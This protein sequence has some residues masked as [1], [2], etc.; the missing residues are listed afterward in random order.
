MPDVSTDLARGANESDQSS[1][2]EQGKNCKTAAGGDDMV[3]EETKGEK[4]Q[5]KTAHSTK[6]EIIPSQS[7]RLN[8][9]HGAVDETIWIDLANEILTCQNKMSTMSDNG[10]YGEQ[11]KC[12]S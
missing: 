5:M 2:N 4:L 9:R 8:R 10:H 7:G 6:S 3:G 12:A 11:C 1:R